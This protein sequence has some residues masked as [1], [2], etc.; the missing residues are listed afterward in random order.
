METWKIYK[1]TNKIN[2]KCYI[3]QTCRKNPNERWN[4]GKGY[5]GTIFAKAIEKYG[6]DNFEH[7]IIEDGILSEEKAN[8]REMY[9]IEYYNS[10]AGVSGGDG[11]NMTKGGDDRADKGRPVYQI[12]IETRKIIKEF[13]SAL[14]AQRETGIAGVYVSANRD[15]ESCRQFITAGGYFWCFTDEWSEDW[16]PKKG[17][18]NYLD[19][20][21]N[22]ICDCGDKQVCQIDKN[23]NLLDTYKTATAAAKEVGVVSGSISKCCRKQRM[24][25]AGFYWCFKKD[26]ENFEIPQEKPLFFFGARKIVC[27]ETNIIYESITRASKSTN[28]PMSCILAVLSGKYKRAGGYHWE[29][30]N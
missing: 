9:W 22:K 3:G 30:V 8:E 20:N 17:R 1:H 15:A 26:L 28:I 5:N 19:K 4:N 21:G 23:G 18:K 14:N 2:G 12:D 16:K 27:V 6:W 25:A 24:T 29:Y 10:Y 13:P 7:E 11:Y